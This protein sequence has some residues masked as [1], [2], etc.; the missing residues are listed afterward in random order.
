MQKKK[1]YNIYFLLLFFTLYFL[2]KSEKAIQSDQIAS[3]DQNIFFLSNEWYVV[4]V[5]NT[6]ILLQ[7]RTT[8]IENKEKDNSKNFRFDKFH[9][10][11]LFW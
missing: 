9:A 2:K 3:I 11:C 4:P 10:Y 8:K 5:R 7:R 6:Y 1:N